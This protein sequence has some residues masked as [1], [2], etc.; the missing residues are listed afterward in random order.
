VEVLSDFEQFY[1]ISGS[2]KP[3]YNPVSLLEASADQ[4]SEVSTHPTKNA[5]DRRLSGQQRQPQ[6]E[7]VPDFPT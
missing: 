5:F 3:T 6:Q 4:I 1:Q 2:N 7:P